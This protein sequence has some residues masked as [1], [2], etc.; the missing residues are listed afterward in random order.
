[1]FKVLGMGVAVRVRTS[2]LALRPLI[3]SL[4][5]TPNLC[6]SSTMSKPRSRK[7]TSLDKIRWVPMTTSTCP[8]L[9][10]ARMTFCSFFDWSLVSA[11]TRAG[12]APSGS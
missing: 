7:A 10:L 1:M 6:S 2:I 11:S 5:P 8:F 3:F 9:R 12:K 4:W